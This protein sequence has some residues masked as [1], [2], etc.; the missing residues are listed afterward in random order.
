MPDSA[1]LSGRTFSH[2]PILEKLGGGG[3]GVVYKAED[4]KLGRLVA[5]KFLPEDMANDRQALERFQREARAASALDHPNICSIYES[6]EENGQPFIVMQYL[7]G[8]TLRHRISG[9]ALPLDDTLD[10]SIEIAD[11]LDAAHSKGIVH[12]DIKPANIFITTRGHAKILD[13]G[14]AK[15][16]APASGLSMSATQETA[17]AMTPEHLTNPGSTLGTVAYMSPEQVRAKELDSRSDLFSFGVVLYEMATGTAPFRGDSTGVIFD[18]I[19]NRPVAAPVRLNADVPAE[20]ERIIAKALEKDRETRYQ[21]ASDMRADLKRLKREAESGRSGSSMAAVTEASSPSAGANVGSSSQAVS[22]A[23]QSAAA[24]QAQSGTA[25]AS[26]SHASGSSVVVEAAKQN[27]GKLIAAGVVVLLLVIGAGYGIY[28]LFAGKGVVP[29][30]N[31]SISQLTKNGKSARAAISPDGKYILSEVIDGG[32]ASLW[33]R[34]VPTNSNTPVI[35][36]A[37]SLYTNLG[38]STDGNYIYF[39]KAEAAIGS[40]NNLFRAPVLGGAPQLLVRDIDSDI[41]FSSDGKRFAFMRDNDPDVGKFQFRTANADG[42]DEKMFATGP[43]SEASRFVA[44]LPNENRVA[45]PEYQIGDML[46]VINLFDVATGQAKPIA[47][48]KE[49]YFERLVWLPDGKGMLGLYQD[50]SSHYTR[51]QIGFIAYP[52]GQF[53]AVTKDTNSYRTLTLSGDAKT[54]ATVQQKTL[55]SFYTFP[56]TGMGANVPAPALPQEKDISDF[57]WVG[58]GGFYLR[59][60]QDF[61]RV[62]VDGSNK[63]VLLSNVGLY[64]IDSCADGRTVL[65]SWEGPNEAAVVNIWRTDANGGDAKQIPTG[66]FDDFPKCSAD[67]KRVYYTDENNAKLMRVPVDGSSKPAIIPGTTVANGIVSSHDLGVSPDGKYLACVVTLTP[68]NGASAG[69]QKIALVPLDAGAEPQT[70][71]I[72]PDPRVKGH[73]SFTSDGKALIYSILENGV[74]NLWMQPLDGSRGR[75]ITNF[76]S[77]VIEAVHLSPDGKSIGMIRS[78]T[79][80]DVVLL[81]DTGAGAQ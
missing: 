69:V 44:W 17:A 43:M 57:A 25:H 79:E 68:T 30:Q 6:A 29:F 63:S 50:P 58:A 62:S 12:R 2:Y 4:T 28:S 65:F 38:F 80:S 21:H 31:F 66:K 23:A 54:L 70:R 78:Q 35:A 5:L 41:S 9:R 48:Y 55:R 75:Q 22:A 37:D 59:E 56:A 64:G 16:L 36:P 61:E 18:A 60:E 46:T 53:H 13:F 52:G 45:R 24:V 7:D 15:T 3:M 77:E 11:A 34:N 26:G 71:M 49:K 81:N 73:L 32:K 51:Y 14:L 67:S 76:T 42:S 39:T 8:Q 27:K 33:L 19:M 47:S 72:D 20:L 40:V 74:E 1:P 10:F